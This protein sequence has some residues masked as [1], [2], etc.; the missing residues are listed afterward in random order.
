[1]VCQTNHD[2]E[3][4]N[5][6]AQALLQQRGQLSR[7]GLD[8]S[9]ERFFVPGDRI[10]PRRPSRNSARPGTP[11]ATSST[12]PVAS[13]PPSSPAGSTSTGDRLVVDFD[14]HRVIARSFFDHHPDP[15][16]R[17][18]AGI[19]HA[20]ALTSYSTQFQTLPAFTGAS[21]MS[22]V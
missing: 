22:G 10:T 4:L 21:R 17:R 15:D 14:G 20:Y 9:D 8:A 3:V 13:S 16:R 11:H 19:D 1:M 7:H 6:A 2:R 12:A 5:R 18:V